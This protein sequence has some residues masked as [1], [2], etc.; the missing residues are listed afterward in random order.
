M[1]EMEEEVDKLVEEEEELEEIKS[2][3]EFEKIKKE[4]NREIGLLYLDVDL[5]DDLRICNESA[6]SILGKNALESCL[7]FC[8]RY[9]LW[10]FDNKMFRDVTLMNEMFNLISSKIIGKNLEY[11]V[12][13]PEQELAEIKSVEFKYEQFNFM[14]KYSYIYG[15]NGVEL[16]KFIGDY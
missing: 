5:S 13:P 16:S 9:S 12:N 8:H 7:S 14:D 2:K 4:H 15:E 6:N 3:I 1:K 11:A 10:Y